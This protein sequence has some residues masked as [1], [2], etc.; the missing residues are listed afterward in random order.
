MSESHLA[1]RED[2]SREECGVRANP[3]ELTKRRKGDGYPR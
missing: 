2:H 3:A 1:P